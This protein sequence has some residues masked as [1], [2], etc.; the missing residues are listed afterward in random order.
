MNDQ[1]LGFRPEDDLKIITVTTLNE[2][3]PTN[4]KAKTTWILHSL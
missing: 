1:T 3:L 4:V 2:G